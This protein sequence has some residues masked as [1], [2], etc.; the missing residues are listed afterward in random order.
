MHERDAFLELRLLVLRRGL[1]RPLEVVQHGQQLL[2]E[3]LVGA[4]DQRLLVARRPACG[5]CRS[6]PR[7]AAGRSRYSSRSPPSQL[8]L[9]ELLEL[10][11][12]G[13]LLRRASGVTCLFVH[14]LVVGV[15]DDLVSSGRA[16]PSPRPRRRLLGARLRVHGLGELV[17]G[18]DER[19]GLRP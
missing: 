18:L 10:G 17:G 14:D 4:R 6:R 3:P 7:R 5:S 15:L 16:A 13:L 1:E 12:F 8:E 19:V 2:D 11:L 9:V